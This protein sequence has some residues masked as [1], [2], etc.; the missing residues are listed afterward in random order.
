MDTSILNDVSGL[1]ERGGG[2]GEKEEDPQYLEGV[3]WKKLR[4]IADGAFSSIFLACDD[5]SGMIYTVK[6]VSS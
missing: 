2:E 6:Q 3:H 1:V 5:S 4:R